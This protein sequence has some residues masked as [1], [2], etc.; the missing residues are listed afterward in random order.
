MS[1]I[2][3]VAGNTNAA[4]PNGDNPAFVLGRFLKDQ[5]IYQTLHAELVIPGS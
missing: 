4:N 1:S 5:K 3:A 2:P